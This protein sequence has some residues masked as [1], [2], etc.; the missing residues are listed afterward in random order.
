MTEA[1]NTFRNPVDFF[2]KQASETPVAP[3]FSTNDQTLTYSQLM[4]AVIRRAGWFCL[5][6]LKRNM[7]VALY[8]GNNIEMTISLFAIWL[9]GAVCIPMNITQKPNKLSAIEESVAP[10]IGFYSDDIAMDFARQFPLFPL[11]GE[12]DYT[13]SVFSPNPDDCAMIMF[14]SGT[15]GV[16]KAVPLTYGALGHNAWE[17]SAK[18]S[19]TSNDRIFINFPPFYTSPIIHVLTLFARGGSVYVNREFLMGT[20]MIDIMRENH[21]TGFGGVPVHF[22][23][24]AGSLKGIDCPKS[25]RFLMNSGEHMPV[26]V[27]KAIRQALP[28]IQFFCV[29]GLTEVAGR[30]CILSPEKLDLKMGS[31]GLPLPGMEISIRDEAGQEV[32]AWEKG[33]VHVSGKCLMKGYLNNPMANE[34]SVKPYGFATGDFG[35]KDADGYLYLQGRRDDIIKVGGEKVSIKMIEEEIYGF[36]A[37]ADFLVYP[38]FDEHMGNVPCFSYVLKAGISF[39]KKE[40]LKYLRKRLPANHIPVHF[41]EVDKIYRSSSGKAV[42]PNSKREQCFESS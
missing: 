42:R 30:L 19:I 1:H 22:T 23:R 10:D 12:S 5:Q 25:I 29:Y 20:A 24:L 9:S 39:S 11:T 16:P 33:E 2:V 36:E 38:V 4:D 3:A 8:T 37:F 34:Q 21:C 28:D 18:L 40:F 14:T 41:Y 35:Y 26:H 13:V 17:T 15:S 32:S 27:L 31:V 6:G 7:R